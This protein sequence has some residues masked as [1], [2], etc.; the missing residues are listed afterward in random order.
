MVLESEK[1]ESVASN[2]ARSNNVVQGVGE[3]QVVW[4][5]ENDCFFVGKGN[6]I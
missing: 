2:E 5:Y 4:G 1:K 3:S 6:Q